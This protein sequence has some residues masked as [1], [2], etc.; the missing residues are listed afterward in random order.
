MSGPSLQR[1]TLLSVIFHITFFAAALLVIRQSSRFVMPSPYIVNLVGPDV[2]STGKGET[3]AVTPAPVP[4]PT[5]T[6]KEKKAMPAEKTKVV[7]QRS[8]DKAEEKYV[9]EQIAA[10]EAKKRIERVAKLRNVISLKG[11]GEGKQVAPRG[12]GMRGGSA[13]IDDYYAKV[14]DDIYRNWGL[15]SA[16]SDKNLEAVI[17]IRI[18]KDGT[19]YVNR[20]EKPSGSSLFD[21]SALNAIAKASPVTPPPYEMEI[22]VRFYP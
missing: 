19:V 5:P 8:L 2:R 20:I 10:L 1:L 17:S 3:H 21:R 14:R 6:P 12:G 9:S 22:G 15:P 4:A 7:K 13:G 18:M 11:S 16:L